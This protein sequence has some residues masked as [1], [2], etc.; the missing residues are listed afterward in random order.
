M[1]VDDGGVSKGISVHKD[2][3]TYE[4]LQNLAGFSRHIATN[5]AKRLIEIPQR[6]PKTKSPLGS[7]PSSNSANT[8]KNL[9]R[10]K[11]L[12]PSTPTLAR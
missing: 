1:P 6:L 2:F 12:E 8:E 3:C 7:G 11:G 4:A 5:D 10:A 9:E